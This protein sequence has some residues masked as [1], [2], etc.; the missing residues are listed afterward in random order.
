MISGGAAVIDAG[1]DFP[2]SVGLLRHLHLQVVEG[3]GHLRAANRRAAA[4]DPQAEIVGRRGLVGVAPLSSRTLNEIVIG[5]P[6]RI[7]V[8]G[9]K[10]ARLNTRAAAAVG[11]LTPLGAGPAPGDRQRRDRQ[12]DRADAPHRR[13]ALSAAASSVVPKAPSR[14]ATMIPRRLMANS[15]GSVCR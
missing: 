3:Q 15:H 11:T 4:G 1:S 2:Q 9:V 7:V 14:R 8:A 10:P 5:R 13:A 12:R 6:A